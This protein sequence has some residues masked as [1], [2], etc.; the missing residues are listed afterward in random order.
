[1]SAKVEAL[2]AVAEAGDRLATSATSLKTAAQLLADAIGRFEVTSRR[3]DE[4]IQALG[5]AVERFAMPSRL[6]EI[7][8]RIAVALETLVARDEAR[9]RPRLVGN[10]ELPFIGER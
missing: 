5:E 2:E 7:S 9:P 3:Q 8:E 6:V 1:M 4:A 10:Q